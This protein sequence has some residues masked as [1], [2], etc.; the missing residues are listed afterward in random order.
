MPDDVLESALRPSGTTDSGSALRKGSD[1]SSAWRKHLS[2]RQ[3]D[4]ILAVIRTFGLD[5]YD[6][7]GRPD[8]RRLDKSVPA[9]ISRSSASDPD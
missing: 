1:P 6:E 9:V 3:I 2:T 8:L 7:D 5:F 4:G